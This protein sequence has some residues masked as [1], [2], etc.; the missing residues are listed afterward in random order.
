VADGYFADSYWAS[1]YFAS[2][3]WGNGG[4]APVITVTPEGHRYIGTAKIVKKLS[5]RQLRA[6]RA[7][8]EA[9]TSE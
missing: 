3:Y 6:I 7:F 1:D 8:L 2:G 9:E 4:T 5:P